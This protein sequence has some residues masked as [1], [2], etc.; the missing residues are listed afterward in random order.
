MLLN[1]IALL[2]R[3]VQLCYRKESSMKRTIVKGG[4]V[5]I[6]AILQGFGMGIFLFPHAIPSGGA[7]GM[8]ILV[9]YWINIRMGPALWIVNFSFL[10]LGVKYLGKRFALWTFIGITMTSLALLFFVCHLMILTRHILYDMII[11]L[12]FIET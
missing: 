1:R 9:N 12:F 4:L 7:G 3:V 2:N 10:L 8:A 5:L 11:C 6:G